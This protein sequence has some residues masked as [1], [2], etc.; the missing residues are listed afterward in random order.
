MGTVPFYKAFEEAGEMTQWF[1]V[2]AAL[3]GDPG[4][5]SSTYMETHSYLRLSSALSWSL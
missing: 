3:P 4:L 5:I 2:L 1:G